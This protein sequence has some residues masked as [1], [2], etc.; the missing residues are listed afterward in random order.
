MA[1]INNWQL[2]LNVF[3]SFCFPSSKHNISLL[4]KY[5]SVEFISIKLALENKSKNGKIKNILS[6]E[7]VTQLVARA[8][9]AVR[10]RKNS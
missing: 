9:M 3:L 4:L 10:R 6:F 1:L 8:F 5:I 7:T 2:S